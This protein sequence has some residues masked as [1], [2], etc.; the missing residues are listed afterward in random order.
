LAGEGGDV[1]A[2]AKNV[3]IGNQTRIPSILFKIA[4]NIGN[5]RDSRSI[6]VQTRIPKD[7]NGSKVRGRFLLRVGIK[8][9]RGD[10]LASAKNVPIG[11]QTRIPSI[12]F[13]IAS[14]IGN[15]RVSISIIQ[16]RIPTCRVVCASK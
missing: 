5:T 16:S 7:V 12:L 13:K 14:N 2:S 10:V 9:P 11:N 6:L 8:T 1:L 15:T 3:P 4:A